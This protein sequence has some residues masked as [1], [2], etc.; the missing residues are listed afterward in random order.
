MTDRI[1]RFVAMA[2]L[3]AGVVAGPIGCSSTPP[4]PTTPTPQEWEDFAQ[5]MVVAIVQSGVV[6]RYP[7]DARGVVPIAIGE[8]RNR[9]TNRWASDEADIMFNK[10]ETAL[11]T[12]EK[13]TASS[14]FGKA[15]SPTRDLLMQIQ[16]INP[17]LLEQQVSIPRLVLDGEIIAVETQSGRYRNYYYQVKCRL[18]D[19]N[20]ADVVWTRDISVSRDWQRPSVGW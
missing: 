17:E 3:G 18:H 9:S 8:F 5:R 15:G 7:P 1:L 16:A 11:V 10:I 4:P 2:L 12:S 13:V 6:D 20:Q 14:Y 19:P